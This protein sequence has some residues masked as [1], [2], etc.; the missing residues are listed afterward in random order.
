ML[1][2]I[3]NTDNKN[4]QLN[5]LRKSDTHGKSILVTTGQIQIIPSKTLLSYR[6]IWCDLVF[7]FDK[8]D[9]STTKT[10]FEVVSKRNLVT[11][12]SLKSFLN[13]CSVPAFLKS[14]KDFLNK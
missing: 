5:P 1:K 12:E 7:D 2:C 4:P 11:A 14:K 3:S 10:Y 8:L 6:P 9:G 13:G